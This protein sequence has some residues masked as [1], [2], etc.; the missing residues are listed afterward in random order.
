MNRVAQ[1]IPRQI[2]C[3]ESTQA[4]L[5]SEVIQ[6]VA[7]RHLCWVRPLLLAMTASTPPDTIDLRCTSDLLWP[8][9]RFRAALDTE[10]I[11]LLMSVKQ[12]PRQ[13]KQLQAQNQLN[14]FVKQLWLANS[15]PTT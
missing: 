13:D 1:F 3:L 5:Y 15:S 7:S 8:L 14:E 11:S 10:V 6:V 4:C 12:S 9:E 2:V